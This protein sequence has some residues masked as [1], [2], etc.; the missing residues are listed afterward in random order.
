M[1]QGKLPHKFAE[2][3]IELEN[4]FATE[5]YGKDDNKMIASLSELMGLYSVSFKL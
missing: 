5:E 1:K 4:K 3:V 2:R